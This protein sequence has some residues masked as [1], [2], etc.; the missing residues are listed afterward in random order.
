MSKCSYEMALFNRG[1]KEKRVRG[2]EKR[3]RGKVINFCIFRKR[4]CI[5]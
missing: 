4:G 3:V 1:R 5:W 2:K